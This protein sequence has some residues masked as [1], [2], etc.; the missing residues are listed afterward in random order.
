[1]RRNWYILLISLLLSL[2]GTAVRAQYVNVVCAGDTGAVYFV[3][4]WENSTFNWTVEGGVITRDYGD[5]IIVDWLVPPGEYH[6][7]VQEISD[8]G[9]AGEL[10]M[11]TVLV[12]GT[13]LNLGGDQGVCDGEMI[14]FSPEGDFYDYLWQDGSTGSEFTTDQEGWISLVVS[15]DYGCVAKDSLYL[16]IYDLPV[17][18]IGNDTTICSDEGL[19]L[20]AGDGFESYTWMSGAISQQI[21]V[22]KGANR[23]WVIVEDINGCEGGDTIN[24]GEC[25][26]AYYFRDIP[27]AITPN[28]DGTNDVW[29][30]TKLDDYSSAVV[31]IFDRWGTLVWKSE[32]GYSIPWD[33]R[34]MKGN[35]VPMASYHFVIDL[36]AGTV[37]RL[38]GIITVI[39]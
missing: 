32:P 12:S 19:L 38:T 34:D 37:D 13:E 1:M 10:Q 30:L 24:I 7:S 15:D 11:G 18:D 3:D 29:V 27:T 22:Y 31:E 28:G 17:V 35:L 36:G 23:A 16:S 5:T 33:G 2:F 21:V 39:R 6:L 9:C 4:G 26:P 14:T 25:D 8:Q 20:D